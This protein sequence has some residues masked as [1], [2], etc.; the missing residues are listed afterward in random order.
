MNMNGN[1][2]NMFDKWHN[3]VIEKMERA[4]QYVH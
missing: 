3:N 1:N 2:K 4:G